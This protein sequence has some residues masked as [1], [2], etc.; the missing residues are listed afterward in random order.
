MLQSE[1][2]L[3]PSD[4]LSFSQPCSFIGMRENKL[5]KSSE[6]ATMLNYSIFNESILLIV[7]SG[8]HCHT[9]EEQPPHPVVPQGPY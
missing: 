4:S 8:E 1:L 2:F 7:M 5:D 9:A 6:V 3:Q